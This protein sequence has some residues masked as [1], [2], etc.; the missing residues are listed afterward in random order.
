MNLVA[1]SKVNEE[2]DIRM[3]SLSEALGKDVD[4][5]WCTPIFFRGISEY[6]NVELKMR[7]LSQ[8]EVRDICHIQ[9]RRYANPDWTFGAGD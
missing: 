3:L 2:E 5:D 1:L 4:F 6:F 7:V 9:K 8:E